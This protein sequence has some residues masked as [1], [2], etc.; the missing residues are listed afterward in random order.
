MTARMDRDHAVGHGGPQHAA[1]A[2]AGGPGKR[3]RAEELGGGEGLPAEPRA[4][5]ER[6]LGHDLSGV[7][8]HTGDAAAEH[9]SRVNARAYA[10]GLDIVFGRGEYRPHD[11]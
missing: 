11:P 3:T 7:R 6:S 2:P 5:F 1:G 8:V 4:R 10:T 9:A